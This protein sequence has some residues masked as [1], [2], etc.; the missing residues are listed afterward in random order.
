MG[1][2]L[3]NNGQFVSTGDPATVD[4]ATPFIL[5]QLGHVTALVKTDYP[6][7][8]RLFQFVKRTSDD[9][10]T[11]AAGKLAYWVDYDD[12]L[13]TMDVSEC[14]DGAG[15]ITGT[16]YNHVAGVFLGA[17]PT[18]GQYGY[19]QVGGIADVFIKETP[20]TNPTSAGLPIIATSTDGQADV[21]A[22]YDSTTIARTV[23]IIGKAIEAGTGNSATECI[24]TIDRVGW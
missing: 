21:I 9:G 2:D 18:A 1:A 19:I 24:L 4:E 6:K 15:G 10:T 11:A 7:L 22:A 12:F 8:P 20:T 13:V 3:R 5:G 16:G 17:K 23:Q 14:W